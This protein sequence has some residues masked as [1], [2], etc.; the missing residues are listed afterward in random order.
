V[1]SAADTSSRR[2]VT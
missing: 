1:N 2:S